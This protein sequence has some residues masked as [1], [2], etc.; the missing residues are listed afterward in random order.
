MI[1]Y[2]LTFVIAKKSAMKKQQEERSKTPES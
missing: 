2:K 1:A